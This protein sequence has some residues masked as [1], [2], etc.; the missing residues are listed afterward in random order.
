MKRLAI[1]Q[2]NYIPWKGYF[3]LINMVDEFILHDDVQYTK[4]D[5]RNRNKI[6]TSEGSKWLTI[7][8]FVTDSLIPINAVTVADPNWARNHWRKILRQYS[9][10]RHFLD[11]GQIFEELY[12]G[13]EEKYLSQINHRFINAICEILSIST[14]I[15]WS[16]DYELGGGRTEKLVSF[17]RQVGAGIYLSGPAARSY[18]DESLFEAENMKVQWMDYSGYPDYQQMYCPPFIHEVSII[19]LIFNEG[20][21]G[22]RKHMLRFNSDRH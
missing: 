22:A 3:D 5:W 18:M 2:S 8:V 19:D 12:L 15:S 10:A 14:R 20:A 13:S 16:T 9:K 21:E 7:P 17:C 4:Q 1:I 6:K 11:Y